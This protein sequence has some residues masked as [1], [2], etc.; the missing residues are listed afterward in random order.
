MT[1]GGMNTVRGYTEGLLIGKN[2]YMIG[3]ELQFP[4]LP[5][6]IKSRDKSKYIPFVGNYLK[7]FVFWDFAGIF[8]YK[9]SGV[10]AQ[11]THKEDYLT[12]LGCGF[13]I[14]LPKDLSL[15]LA[16]GFPLFYNNHEDRHRWGRFHFDLNISPDFDYILKHRKPK[17]EPVEM[18]QA[19]PQPEQT[20]QSIQ[21]AQQTQE[22]QPM[23][24][25]SQDKV[26]FA[27]DV[28]PAV[29][30]APVQEKNVVNVSNTKKKIPSNR[31]KI[32]EDVF[33]S[34]NTVNLD[35]T[36]DEEDENSDNSIRTDILK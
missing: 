1:A 20:A 23:Q 4:I 25:Q 7:G 18:V 13:K 6:A 27:N 32:G 10:G 33:G 19:P 28:K 31:A 5:R 2:G 8:P 35:L 16:W 3:T 9:G 30:E 21:T 24:E 11:T 36:S 29:E 26:Q 12:S 34:E 15:R 22:T 17:G 14:N